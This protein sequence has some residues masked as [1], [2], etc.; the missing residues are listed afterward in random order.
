[1]SEDAK[2]P[3][4]VVETV[5]A[6][7]AATVWRAVT[8][9]IGAWWPAEFYSGG[10]PA[11]RSFHLEAT[12][13]GRM[14]EDWGDGGGG[15][16]ATVLAVEPGR[17]LELVGHVTPQW[18]GPNTWIGGLTLEEEGDGVRLRFEEAAFGHLGE[19]YQEEKTKGWRFL[20][21]GALRAH[22]EGTEPPVWQE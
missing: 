2:H 13:G 19:R 12:P 3:R 5:I 1:M 21:D 17:R 6:A 18:G 9:E 11:N 10:D 22:V 7:D 15:L 14:Y 4:V 16:W 8:E 20:F